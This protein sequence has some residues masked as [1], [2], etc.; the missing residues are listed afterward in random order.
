[1][2]FDLGQPMPGVTISS[3][4]M[5]QAVNYYNNVSLSGYISSL[6]LH[7]VQLA[8]T[9]S[10]YPTQKAP[11][12]PRD[13][14]RPFVAIACI[15]FILSYL[16]PEPTLYVRGCNFSTAFAFYGWLELRFPLE[17][18]TEGTNN[19]ASAEGS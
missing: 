2:A 19:A 12:F 3:I 7:C 18:Q 6:L 16:I 5:M 4:I 1:M 14:T 15:L 8:L 13:K 11:R 10:T 9:L 17:A